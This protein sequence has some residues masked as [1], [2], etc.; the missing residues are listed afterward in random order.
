MIHH[1]SIAARD[2]Q[3]VAEVLA[4]F[5]GGSATRFPPN[6]AAGS[7]IRMTNMAPG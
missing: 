7:R 3:H 6:P 5:M 4:A 2:P 1:L